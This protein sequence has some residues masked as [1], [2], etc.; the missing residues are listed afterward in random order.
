MARDT[1]LIP[2][3]II[4]ED[5]YGTC[6]RKG[7]EYTLRMLK[8]TDEFYEDY[9]NQLIDSLEDE[10]KDKERIKKKY[11]ALKKLYLEKKEKEN[12]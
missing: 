7:L 1:Y 3:I 9:T 5:I 4:D 2:D 10:K 11:Q 12:K 6:K 8:D